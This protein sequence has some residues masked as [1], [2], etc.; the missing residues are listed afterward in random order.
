MQVLLSYP[1]HAAYP[2]LTVSVISNAG[3][4]GS[5]FAGDDGCE[6]RRTFDTPLPID[7]VLDQLAARSRALA[8][9]QSEPPGA[10]ATTRRR[11]LLDAAL[12]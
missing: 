2:V 4:T 11:A 6:T 9:V 7:A 10:A 3:V 8:A 1:A 12:A 5:A